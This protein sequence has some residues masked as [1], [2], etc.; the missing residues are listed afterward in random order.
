MRPAMDKDRS[1]V[2]AE[3]TFIEAQ[4]LFEQGKAEPIRTSIGKREEALAGHGFVVVQAPTNG[5]KQRRSVLTRLLTFRSAALLAA[6][7]DASG[8]CATSRFAFR[9]TPLARTTLGHR[10]PL[11]SV[12]RP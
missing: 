1:K 11:L 2:L 12:G 9:I 3:W 7:A 10:S 5:A 8:Q 6:F 4:Q